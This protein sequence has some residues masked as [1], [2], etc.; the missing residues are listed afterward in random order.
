[1]SFQ[2]RFFIF[3]SGY[4]MLIALVLIP[5]FGGIFSLFLPVLKR[6]LISLMHGNGLRE[7]YEILQSMFITLLD[8]LEKKGLITH[9]EWVQRMQE[10]IM[11]NTDSFN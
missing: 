7:S 8:L 10:R 3:C 11:K 9:Q 2:E 6:V 5:L 1:M 4:G